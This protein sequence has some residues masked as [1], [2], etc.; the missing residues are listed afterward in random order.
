[1]SA[2]NVAWV[3][4]HSPYKGVKFGIHQAM[5]DIA[6]AAHGNEIWMRHDKL[7]AMARTSR[8]SVSRFCTEMIEDGLLELV[9]DNSQNGRN[10]ASRYRLLCPADAEVMYDRFTK[11]GRPDDTQPEVEGQ[12]ISRFR[13]SVSQK[14]RERM[15]EV[16]APTLLDGLYEEDVIDVD[17]DGPLAPVLS[18]NPPA[19]SRRADPDKPQTS[20]EAYERLSDL[21]ISPDDDAE[22][23]AASGL[24][25]AY[26]TLW[27]TENGLG[28]MR[29]NSWHGEVRSMAKHLMSA[30]ALPPQV[31][32]QIVMEWHDKNMEF[33][34]SGGTASR[35]GYIKTIAQS[36][37]D[38]GNGMAQHGID[39]KGTSRRQHE[40]NTRQAPIA[41][42]AHLA[43]LI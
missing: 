30:E 16:D 13:K 17:P 36:W 19:G 5:A 31:V 4:R 23:K 42:R 2:E 1:M 26:Y 39:G 18:M 7:A 21:P 32:A 10:D 11:S 8:S 24:V 14:Q 25:L 34:A 12:Q 38:R 43:N 33:T 3:Y 29:N 28:R 15:E 6:N 27:R 22:L 35:P 41:D 9:E 40:T 37:I 20:Q